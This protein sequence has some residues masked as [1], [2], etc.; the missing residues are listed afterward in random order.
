MYVVLSANG[1]IG[2]AVASALLAKGK[3]V[4]AVGRDA[5]KL[6]LLMDKGAEPYIGS[7]KDEDFLKQ[8][9][10]G[11]EAAYVMIPADFGAPVYRAFQNEVGEAITRGLD[12]ASVPYAVNI[13]SS[14]AHSDVNNGVVG[15]LY[16]QEQRL[17][18]LTRTNVMHLRPAYFMENMLGSLHSIRR[19]C[20]V[21]MPFDPKLAFPVVAVKDIAAAVVH[22]LESRDF[23]HGRVLDLLGPRDITPLEMT[24]TL[25]D[26]VGQSGVS[27]VQTSIESMYL[28]LTRSGMTPSGA[29]SL[30]EYMRSLSE[31]RLYESA[32][33]TAESTTPTT[34]EQFAEQFAKAY[35]AAYHSLS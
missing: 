28:G 7:L 4:R 34:F 19:S 2:S 15:G 5:R 23:H 25:G 14:G 24:R 18:R 29:K 3:P 13:S 35:A 20:T 6:Q 21:S 1:G 8:A 17:N 16:D 30:T 12:H 26:A 32:L 27:Y 10:K 11:A 9:F 22:H 31:G 33:R